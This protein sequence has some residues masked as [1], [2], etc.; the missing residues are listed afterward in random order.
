MAPDQYR[1]VFAK[2]IRSADAYFTLYARWAVGTES[3]ARLGLAI[4]RKSARRAV[5]RV[6][7]KRIVRESFRRHRVDLT[8]VDVIVTCRTD[9]VTA[10]NDV[11]HR[12]LSRHWS[13]LRDQLCASSCT[14]S[15]AD[16]S[17]S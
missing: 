17:C 4:S 15:S 9:A 1:R 3:H 13:R 6:R 7:I 2:P 11:L 10:A 5:D 12:S 8:A 16:T 14:P